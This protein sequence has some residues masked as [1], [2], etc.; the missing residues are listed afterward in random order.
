MAERPWTPRQKNCIDARGGTVIVSAAAGSGKTAVLI[1][2]IVSLICDPEHPLNVNNLLVVTFTKAAA[3]EMRSRLHERLAEKIALDPHNKHLQH[4]QLLL[5]QASIS[6]VHSFCGKLLRE[7]AP[8]VSVSPRFKVA[9]STTLELMRADTVRHVVEEAY[10]QGDPAFLALCDQITSDKGD[11]NLTEQILRIYDFIGAHP[12]PAQ[13]LATQRARFH[14][15]TP[16]ADTVWGQIILSQAKTD[17]LS[18]KELLTTAIDEMAN[19]EKMSAA[20]GMSFSTSLSSIID[21]IGAID[22]GWDTAVDAVASIRFDDLKPLSKYEDVDFKNHIQG[23][24][25]YAKELINSHVKPYVTGSESELRQSILDAAP[26]VDCLF[27]LVE[28]FSTAFSAAKAEQ[29]LLDFTDLEHLTLSLLATPAE[30]GGFERTEIAKEIGAR[31]THIMVDEYQDTNA[32]QDTLFSALSNNEQNLFFVG[33][34]KQSIYG[35]RQAM[36]SIFRDRR[37]NCFVYDGKQYPAAITLGNN[38]RSRKQVTESVNFLFR[39]L[40][41]KN[42]GGIDYDEREELVSSA[43]FEAE[44]NDAYNTELLIL[45]TNM[46]EEDLKAYEA[47]ARLIGEKILSMIHDGFQVSA[48]GGLRPA[49]YRDFCILL[50]STSTTAPIYMNTLQLMGIPVLTGNKDSFFDRAEIHTALCVLRSIDNPLL[51]IPLLGAMMSPIFG[52]TPDDLTII[53]QCNKD[54]A[55]YTAVRQLS[56]NKDELAEKCKR[57]LQTLDTYRTLSVSLPSD[58]LIRRIFDDTDMLSIMSAKSGGES[59][60]ANLRKLYD[61]ARHFE[62]QDARGLSAFIRY[63]DRLEEKGIHVESASSTSQNAVQIMT[64]HGSKGL[65]FPVVFTAALT[66]TFSNK[67][68]AGGLLLHAEHGVGITLNDRH[69]MQSFDTVHHTAL[70]MAIKQEEHNEELRLLYVAMTRAKD[71][72]ILVLTVQNLA[73]R[74]EDV[75]PAASAGT[76]LP[77]SFVLHASNAGKWVLAAFLQHEA[78]DTLRFYCKG[79]APSSNTADGLTVS[80][81]SPQSFDQQAEIL[82]DDTPP[83]PLDELTERFDYRYPYAALGSIAAKLTASQAAHQKSE[84]V[85]H[86]ERPAFLSKHGLTPAERGTATHLFLEHVQL[87]SRLSAEEQACQ[88]TEKGILTVEQRQS[89]ALPALQRFLNSPLAAR[90]AKADSLLR[91]VPFAFERTLTQLGI[92]LDDVP[93][94][95]HEETVIVQ[96]IADAIFIEGDEAVIVDYKTDRVDSGE[97][98]CDRYHDQLAIYKEAVERALHKRVKSCLIYSFHLNATVEV[99]I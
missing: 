1:E 83:L 36:P 47:E 82:G 44:D 93:R 61:L 13:W 18:A 50:R 91:E 6:T 7:F 86:L 34:I 62:D 94:D 65:E 29:N 60:T 42:T 15:D 30:D 24:R 77:S 66:K 54:A 78:A 56:R 2:R 20:Y 89:L 69:K 16:L 58:K 72:L 85:V 23:L 8:L 70:S 73:K 39:R 31:F 3:A 76:P 52:F 67:S 35:F 41:T 43:K 87:D 63:L 48:K 84:H 64:I 14:E 38:F 75:F 17:L 80:I 11:D 27:S 59:R 57:F 97:V 12:F 28:K 79:D 9:E 95:C 74:L 21:A 55:L 22:G 98:L 25:N 81:L 96:G 4:Q 71:K 90:M 53:R 99:V 51:D 10:A 40:M 19:D 46:L 5:P 49:T 37:D 68:T 88:L 92:S 26:I 45:Q 33:D 32:T